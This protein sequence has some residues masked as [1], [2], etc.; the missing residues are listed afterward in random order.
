MAENTINVPASN[1]TVD[2]LHQAIVEQVASAVGGV[3]QGA[4]EDVRKY[5]GEI[6]TSLAMAMALP[7]DRRAQ[8]LAELKGQL[9]ALAELNRIRVST[10]AQ[11]TLNTIITLASGILSSVLTAFGAGLGVAAAGAVSQALGGPKNAGGLTPAQANY[12]GGQVGGAGQPRVNNAPTD[13]NVA[14][15]A[16]ARTIK[17]KAE[18]INVPPLGETRIEE[19][20]EASAKANPSDASNTPR[21]LNDQELAETERLADELTNKMIDEDNHR[22]G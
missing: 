2:Q 7:E 18:T 3:V 12:R 8:V 1:L 20:S 9:G 4:A 11:A 21:I 17:G 15:R 22:R 6:S 19:T 13:E 10:T 5:A 14:A 16:G